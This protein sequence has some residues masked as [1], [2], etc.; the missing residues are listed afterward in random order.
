MD[1]RASVHV[2]VEVSFALQY[3]R[4]WVLFI[5][6]LD[7]LTIGHIIDVYELHVFGMIKMLR[8]LQIF[9]IMLM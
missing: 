9:I 6:C 7:L 4:A 5:K 1:R 2:Q 8:R 3:K